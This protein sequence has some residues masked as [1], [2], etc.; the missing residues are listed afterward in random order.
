MIQQTVAQCAK[1]QVSRKHTFNLTDTRGT[2][3]N[4][5][6]SQWKVTDEADYEPHNASWRVGSELVR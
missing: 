5:R 1:I 6:V 2:V 4:G 3:E